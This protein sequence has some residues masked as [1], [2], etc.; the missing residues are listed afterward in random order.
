M[1]LYI[2]SFLALAAVPL[3]LGAYGGHLAAEVISDRKHRRNAMLIVWNL[4]AV[5]VV[6]A[7]VQQIM[8]YRADRA[9]KDSSKNRNNGT[10]RN[11]RN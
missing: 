2:T 5:G 1:W 11:N 6:L 9:M 8:T 10:K 3:A 4:A 7:G